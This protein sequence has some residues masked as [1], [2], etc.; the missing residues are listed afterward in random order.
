MVKTGNLDIQVIDND[1]AKGILGA[2]VIVNPEQ[3]GTKFTTDARGHALI[4]NMGVGEIIQIGVV[5]PGYKTQRGQAYAYD[6]MTSNYV[7]AMVV[8]GPNFVGVGSAP[9]NMTEA[10]VSSD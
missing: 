9:A 4:P 8:G 1:T 3:E 2:L 7:Y 6:G 5:K 10:T